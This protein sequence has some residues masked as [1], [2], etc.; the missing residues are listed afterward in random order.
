MNSDNFTSCLVRLPM[1]FDLSIA[2][3]KDI[4]EII[5]SIK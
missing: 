4:V 2:E 1:Y 5:K 3:V